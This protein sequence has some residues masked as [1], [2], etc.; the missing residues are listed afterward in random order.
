MRERSET[1][2]RILCLVLGALLLFQI[3]RGFVQ[4]DPLG[5]LTIPQLPSLA[6]AADS[7]TGKA[8]NSTPASSKPGTNAVGARSASGDTNVNHASNKDATNQPA[9][10]PA[11]N[12]AAKAEQAS[13]QPPGETAT[14]AR[15][16]NTS[17]GKKTANTGTNSPLAEEAAQSSSNILAQA[18]GNKTNRPSAKADTNSTASPNKGKTSAPAGDS[19]MPGMGSGPAKKPPELPLPIQAQVVKVTESELL[20]PV[21]HPQP[22]ALLGIVGDVAFLR[23]PSG[24]TG[25][26]KEG[27]ELAGL[28]LLRI[29]TNRVLVEQ[30]GQ[31]QELMIFSGLG[32]ESLLPK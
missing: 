14:P 3:V 21:I 28:K 16:T 22:M 20:G 4:S 30:G 12:A 13:P 25:L 2:L 17:S 31:K 1:Y 10:K 5:K 18:D 15:Q 8:T 7:P 24:Q 9:G 29:G 23:A 32:G 26:V 27:D 11:T 6:D 19:A